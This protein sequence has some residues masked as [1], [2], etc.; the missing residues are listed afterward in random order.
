MHVTVV[1]LLYPDFKYLL[2]QFIYGKWQREW[3]GFNS[4]LNGI[5]PL[6]A[7]WKSAYRDSRREERVLSRLRTGS[8][9]FLIQQYLDPDLGR[10]RCGFCRV[11]MTLE[12]LLINCVQFAAHRVDIISYFRKYRID[13]N[14]NN[15]LNDDFPHNKL[16]HF[17]KATNF[18]GRI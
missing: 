7:D 3:A 8:C 16:F 2:R 11:N 18:I 13:F 17:L 10:A 14:I 6:I 12:H 4:R 15:I 9:R 5:K 1:P